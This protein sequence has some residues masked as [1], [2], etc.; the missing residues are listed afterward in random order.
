M[1]VGLPL[2]EFLDESNRV[3]YPEGAEF[4]T[5]WPT[6]CKLT[7][8]MKTQII[9][10]FYDRLTSHAFP[11]FWLRRWWNLINREQDKWIKLIDSESSIRPEDA[12]Y[13]YD[14]TEKSTYQTI[15]SG[16]SHAERTAGSSG[17][18]TTYTSDTPEGSVSDIEEFMSEAGKTVT[19]STDNSSSDATDN[20]QNN[21][22]ATLTR[23]GNIGGMTA[24]QII[25][26][27]REATEWCAYDEVIFPS[28]EK[29]FIGLYGGEY[30][31]GYTV[32]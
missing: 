12:I 9:N 14:M 30:G 13:N 15:S 26:G 18:G 6:G 29:M 8:E 10:E 17:D 28:L 25:G 20:T 22:S 27:Y 3:I 16:N 24:A 19:T 11:Q 2:F 31:Y 4:P 1:S 7:D 32:N 21:G 5:L 23:K